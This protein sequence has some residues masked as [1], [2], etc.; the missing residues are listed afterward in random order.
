MTYNAQEVSQRGGSPIEFYLWTRGLV[1]W[2]YT[3][4]DAPVTHLAQ[5]YAPAPISRPVIEDSAELNQTT[6]QI[7]A[8]R[9][10]VVSNQFIAYP[11]GEVVTL[12][13]FRQHRTDGGNEVKTIW[14]GRV[15]SAQWEGE[16]SIL[17]CEPISTSMKRTG[18]RRRYG[19]QCEHVLYGTDCKVVP[20]TYRVQG[21][22][23][24]ISGNLATIAAAAGEAD[25]YFNGG[26]LWW[27]LPDGRKEARMII[28]HTGDQITLSAPMQ[29]V[30][31]GDDIELYP[32]CN[33]TIEQCDARYGNKDNNGGFMFSPDVNPF[34]GK[35]LY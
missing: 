24:A 26:F 18:L 10:F 5:V 22:I 20:A 32:G 23:A 27:Q 7:K 6:L 30:Q 12:K 9:D 8:P 13:I 28:D 17:H 21:T 4:A 31:V 35:T 3:S 11:P 25:G 33:H 2:T 29:Q 15:L 34:G 1:T 16:Y 19:R 14:I